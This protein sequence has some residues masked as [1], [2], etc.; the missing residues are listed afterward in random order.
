ME[1]FLLQS[2]KGNNSKSINARVTVLALCISLMLI[3]IYLKFLE[4]IL[5]R[6]QVTE[7]THFCEGK[8]SGHT[9]VKDKVPR[10]I[11]QNV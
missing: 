9:F 6:F 11:I 2:S 8:K 7:W 3:D 1:T 5:N 10:E 4:D